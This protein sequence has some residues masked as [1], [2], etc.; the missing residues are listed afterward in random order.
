MEEKNIKIMQEK[1]KERELICINKNHAD[2]SLVFLEFSKSHE[3]PF[4]HVVITKELNRS[5]IDYSGVG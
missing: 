5:F 3:K 4:F 2:L 1:K